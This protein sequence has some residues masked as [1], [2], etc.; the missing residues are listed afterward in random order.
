MRLDTNLDPDVRPG[1][2]VYA[3]LGFDT[4]DLAGEVIP[5]MRATVREA[6]A[7]AVA[8]LPP[9][10]RVRTEDHR[11]PGPEGAPELTVR[12]YRPVARPETLPGL[13]WIHGG[14]MILG[15][16]GMD[17]GTCQAYAEQVGCSVVSVDYRLAPE[18][19]HP[20]P[21]E[22]CYAGLLW[23]ARNAGRLGIDPARLAVGG[24][25]AGGGLAA[26]TVLLARDRGGPPVVF[27]LLV[28][29][30]LDDRNDSPSARE[31]SGIVSWSREHNHSGWAALLGD[32]AGGPEVPAYAA[33]ARATDLS[34]LP[35]ALIQVGELEV[36][37]DEDVDY[38][39]RLLRAGV[40]VELHIYPGA[41]HG[42]DIFVPTAGLSLRMQQERVAALTRAL[43]R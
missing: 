27:Q 40:P 8:E 37:R 13:Y 16:V 41:Y 25:S 12:V 6:F 30:M 29:P 38:A 7:A 21:V 4:Q 36:F 39:V 28:Y 2:D 15:D 17:D 31:F 42:C 33:P 43:Y 1:L 14:G 20:A 18:N 10:D 11:A 9:N 35:P 3:A 24:A 32:S 19:P 23:T 5:R 34:G 26:A 22:D